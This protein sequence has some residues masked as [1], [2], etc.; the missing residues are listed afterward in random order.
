MSWF[1]F[2]LI[3]TLGWGCADLF[4][5]KSSV[6]SD[7]YSHLKISVWVG[8]GLGLCAVVLLPFSEKLTSPP[9]FFLSALRYTPASLAYILSMII[10]YAGMRYLE[11]SIISPV[12]NAS[13]ALSAICITVWFLLCGRIT[14]LR[15]E[16]SLL[17]LFGTLLIVAGVFTLALVEQRL[18]RDAQKN[19]A[20]THTR[21]YK[22]G[23]LALLFP[24]LY[25]LFDT[26]GTAADGIL[27]DEET[28]LGLPETD[29]LILY[30]FTFFLI[31]IGCYFVLRWKTGR[32]YNPF[33]KGE[34]PKAVAAVA[35]TFGQVFYIYAMA[36]NPVLAAPMIAA[37]CIV[38]VILS[39]LFLGEKLTRAQSVCVIAVIAGILLLGISEGM[40]E[41]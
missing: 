3:A 37:Y 8:L 11:I 40:G 28:G 38:S 4:Y 7:R 20:P 24:L 22:Y 29:I 12:Q 2:A 41:L 18:S 1:W 21:T 9:D 13:G 5:K 17:D 14:D 26:V 27:L 16:F 10:G 33:A 39:R 35:E 32:F 19:S 34:Y 31:G 15:D 6:E 30:G 23:A 25:C 36:S